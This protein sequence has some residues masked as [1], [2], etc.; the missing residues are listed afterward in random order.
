MPRRRAFLREMVSMPRSALAAS[1]DGASARSVRALLLLLLGL[2]AGWPAI[3][4]AQAHDLPD[5]INVQMFAKPEGE[6]LHVLARV[7]LALLEGV[8]LP[9][10]GAGYLDL[11]RLDEGLERA[12]MAVA[13]SFLFLED[14]VRLAPAR[15][16]WRISQPSEEA[17]GS[18]E[19]ARA[20]VLGP[21]LPDNAN[22]FWNQGYYDVY[23]EYP[24]SSAAGEFALET[25]VR[26][27][28]GILKLS[29]EYL[30]PD[31]PARLYD[32]HGD[33]GRL[34][35]DPS[36]HAAALTFVAAGFDHLLE[37]IAY[38]LFLLCLLLPFRVQQPWGLIAVVT[39][40]AIAHSITLIA[41]AMG[42]VPSDDWF[43]LLIEVLIA[44]SIVYLA[45]E[46]IV[47]AWFGLGG[48]RHLRWRCL[49]SAGFGLAY[50]FS[51]AVG[52][53]GELQ[54]A[55]GHLISALLAFIVGIELGQIAFLL[56]A[57]PLLTLVLRSPRA[58]QAG[59]VIGSAFIAHT[60]WHWMLEDAEGLR[61]VRWPEL[62]S[63]S[64]LAGLG[65]ARLLVGVACVL[66][67]QG[68]PLMQ[69]I[70]RPRGAP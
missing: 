53:G 43:P 4:P 66:V 13:R 58:R 42:A 52:L 50:G 10:R 15:A 46:N 36:W 69:R 44:F 38:L 57:I 28:G 23:L 24:V 35:L 55:G 6:R 25:Q 68:R 51:F 33:H 1:V 22:V 31:A 67:W 65:A 45:V 5:E 48:T 14:G 32:L 60:A 59:I 62:P 3:L 49:V 18:F 26:G 34:A 17:F 7:P 20:H 40:F 64:T 61:Y 2:L 56:I 11:P 27:L 54:F 21:S 63:T 47:L 8:A 37:G 70:R 29:V 12:A 9:K 39:S 16:A 19:E 30:P 41:A